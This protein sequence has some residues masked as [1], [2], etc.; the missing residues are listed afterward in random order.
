MDNQNRNNN[1]SNQESEDRNG[2][3]S[4]KEI[5]LRSIRGL[6]NGFCAGLKIRFL[7]SLVTVLFLHHG[8]LK[9]KVHQIIQNAWIHGRNVG[10]F[11]LIYKVIL[12]LL[13]RISHHKYK[14]FPLISGMVA[15]YFAFFKD[16][17]INKQ[18]TLYSISRVIFAFIQ[19]VWLKSHNFSQFSKFFP[20]ISGLA[21][22]L[23]LFIFENEN[24]LLSGTEIKVLGYIYKDSDSWKSWKDF[25]PIDISSKN[26]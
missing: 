20:L 4:V 19:K 24:S 25:I 22:G 17:S 21:W 11:V 12:N 1:G 8:T 16:N 15:G 9:A 18:I 14:Y 3:Q 6:R 7:H 5:A 10:L 2:E 13:Q 23:M 26:R